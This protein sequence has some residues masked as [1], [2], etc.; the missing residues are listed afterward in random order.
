MS[1]HVFLS[2]SAG[3]EGKKE[4]T[5]IVKRTGNRMIKGREQL[6]SRNW[7]KILHLHICQCVPWVTAIKPSF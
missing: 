5:K 3:I 4:D 1:L 2:Q 6:K 7:Q